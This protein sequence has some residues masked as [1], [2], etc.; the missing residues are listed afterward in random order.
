MKR[1][2]RFSKFFRP[3]V[4]ISTGLIIFGLI[5][6]FTMGFN[7]GVDFQAG[8]NQTIQMAYPV[9]SVSYEGKSNAS[10]NVSDAAITLVFSGAEIEQKTVVLDYKTYPT[11]GDLA[12]AL[13]GQNSI[14][15]TLEPG[16][17]T[18]PSTL[19][20]PT[21]QG[22]TLLNQNT[23]VLH[24]APASE[25]ERFASTDK[26]REAI[27]SMGQASVQTINPASSQRYLIRVQD[28]GKDPNFT[29]NARAA[30]LAGL[31]AKFGKNKVVVLKTDFVGARFSQTLGRTSA[32]LVIATLLLILLYSTIRFK[33]E[34]AIGAVMAI[35][36]DALIMVGFV[37][38]TRMEFNASTIAAILTILGYSINDTIV[39]FDRV[40]EERK[41][42][43]TESFRDVLDYAL[44]VTLGRTIIT[45]AATM[46]TVLSLFFFTSG[47]IKNFSLALFVGMVSGTYST[48]YIASAF[49]LWW[50]DRAAKKS[51]GA[52]V[53]VLKEPV[54]TPAK[55]EA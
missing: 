9:A 19:M 18:L 8:I 51:P 30:T 46:L 1:V 48:I 22:N 25:Q 11:V 52:K 53:Q 42:R 6:Y 16:A 27:S 29:S 37:V 3:A 36:H 23:V 2:I 13:S 54:V 33:I 4:I 7:L 10:L 45:T 20:V 47:D 38:W 34:Y 5:G 49:V 41:L 21:Y 26:V 32:I 35:M 50:Q 12:K 28:E 44:S 15:V 39:Q 31:E 17:E 24:R 40:R 14:K 43:P 55:G